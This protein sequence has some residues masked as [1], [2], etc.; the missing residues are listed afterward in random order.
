MTIFVSIASYRDPDLIPTIGD[1]IRRA[2]WPG[3]LRFGICWQHG[4]GEASPRNIGSGRIDVIDVPWRSS[5]GACWARSE[6]M[7]LYEG[8]D[9]FLQLD[10]HHRF[11][12]GWDAILLDQAQR[13][14]AT[15]PLLTTYAAPFQ[16]D[17]PLPAFDVPT[18]MKFNCFRA[19]GTPS[20]GITMEPGWAD[21]E[22][23]VRARFVSAHML[24]T[25]GSFVEDVAYDPELYFYGEE[26]SLAIRAFTHD[27]LPF[28]PSAHL[29]W[30]QDPRRTGPLHW[31]DHVAGRGVEVTAA[32]RDRAS[33]TKVNRFLQDPQVGPL[34]C[35][36]ARSFHEYQVYSG[37]DF[38]RRTASASARRGDEPAPPPPPEAS[39]RTW[40]LR[41]AIDRV[42]LP[43]AALDRPRFW[44]IG[45]HDDQDAELARQDAGPAELGAALARSDGRI[46]IQRQIR[47]P[48]PPARWTVWPVDRRGQWLDRVSGPAA[49][50]LA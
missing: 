18:G 6:I 50:C 20:T 35:G 44:Y 38:R 13:T 19:D 10:S 3:Q 47:S 37:L 49:E 14:G 8:E 39:M 33:L 43:D 23:P 30:H 16:P 9:F 40:T 31:D 1:C 11:V 15:R 2:R 27:Y 21:R 36:T 41:I 48:R 28:H 46:V 45:I 17:R 26:I 24:F 4:R 5:R 42:A 22:R 25:L 29:M 7:K 32:E 12:E 34:A